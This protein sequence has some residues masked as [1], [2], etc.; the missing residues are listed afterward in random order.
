MAEK[1]AAEPD[2]GGPPAKKPKT[3]A[4]PAL[5][6]SLAGLA[7]IITGSSSGVGAA[8]ARAL[9]RRGCDVV[10]N[11]NSSK[12]GADKTAEECRAEG[13]ARAI[14]VQA[15]VGQEDDCKRL[16]EESVKAF[17]RVDLLVNNAGTTK[18]CAHGDLDGL[19]TEDFTRIY[20]TNTVSAFNM[21]KFCAPHMR[22]A[23]SGRVVNVA[24]HAGVY[25]TLGSSLA[26]I[27]SKAALVALT[28]ALGKALG[29]A[30]RVNAVCPGFIEGD[31]LKKG[32]GEQRYEHIKSVCEEKVP[33]GAVSNPDLVADNVLW[34][35][36]AAPNITGEAVVMDAGVGLLVGP[37]L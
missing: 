8:C 11:Y 32:L 19:T 1:K 30:I 29:P 24:S 31:W 18:F 34:L 17:G 3:S 7:A 22:N 16:V 5:G 28:K 21:I 25:H 23:G 9:A 4:A 15:D 36:T 14:V 26:Y 35:L 27:G 37:A 33:L 13:K 12:A 20:Q 6:E 2:D 10:I